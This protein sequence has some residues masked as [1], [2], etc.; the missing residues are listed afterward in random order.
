M[1]AVRPDI[2]NR[3][4]ITRLCSEF[5]ERAFADELLGPVFVDVAKLDLDEHL[6]TIVDFWETVLLGARSYRG[7]AFAPHARLHMQVPLTRR[8]FDRW[9][10]I[11]F[12]TI[13][14]LFAGEVADDAKFRAQR[15]AD[16][17]HARLE[18]PGLDQQYFY[19]PPPA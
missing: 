11:W 14:R 10:A 6:P 15:V 4:D 7:G 2:S 8:H 19:A 9:L 1:P 5:Y 16:A 17:F 12:A 13:D 3:I 18:Q